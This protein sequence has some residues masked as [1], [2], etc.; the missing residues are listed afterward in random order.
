MKK[1]ICGF[2]FT[3]FLIGCGKERDKAG[4]GVAVGYDG[5]GEGTGKYGKVSESDPG[6]GIINSANSATNRRVTVPGTVSRDEPL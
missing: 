2:A 4:A 1:L 6:A 5:S 3:I